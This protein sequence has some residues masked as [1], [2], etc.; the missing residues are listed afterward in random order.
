MNENKVKKYLF[1]DIDGVICTGWSMK[2]PKWDWLKVDNDISYPFFP[3]AVEQLN[4]VLTETD[5][6]IS[7]F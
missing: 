7:K 6:D 3:D 2:Q 1:L 5:A 4:R